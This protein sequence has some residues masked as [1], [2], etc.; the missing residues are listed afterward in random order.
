MF[1]RGLAWTTLFI[2]RLELVTNRASDRYAALPLTLR[3]SFLPFALACLPAL[4]LSLVA[5]PWFMP[6]GVILTLYLVYEA[7][8]SCEAPFFAFD[9]SQA[10][11]RVMMPLYGF[12][13]FWG[14]L[15][16]ANGSASLFL[17]AVCPLFLAIVYAT[18]PALR[19]KLTRKRRRIPYPIGFSIVA[20]FIVPSQVALFWRLIK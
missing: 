10:H 19:Y 16:A 13:P 3:E 20:G 6:L 14:L 1:A 9:R 18:S 11:L 2:Q 7:G 15:L 8:R 17:T 12:M 5:P 4:L